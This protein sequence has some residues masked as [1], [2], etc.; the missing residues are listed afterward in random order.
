MYIISLGNNRYLLRY[1]FI[2][3]AG[4]VV[5]FLPLGVFLPALWHKTG[6]FWRFVV[7]TLLIIAAIETLQFFTLLGRCDIDD[8]ILNFMG[9]C[10]GFAAFKTAKKLQK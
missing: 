3:L 2:N 6:T 9:A 8:V 5:M 4:N 7:W 1:A 10:A